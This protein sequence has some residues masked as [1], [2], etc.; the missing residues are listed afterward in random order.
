MAKWKLHLPLHYIH[1]YA[2]VPEKLDDSLQLITIQYILKIL[3]DMQIIVF[4][5]P[6]QAI[7]GTSTR[8]MH[9]MAINMLMDPF[10]NW[11]LYT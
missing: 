10:L 4:F 7:F 6:L 1:I 8:H 5:S 2:I 9:I 11:L 3:M